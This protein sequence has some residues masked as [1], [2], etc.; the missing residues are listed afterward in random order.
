MTIAEERTF[1]LLARVR[2]WVCALPAHYVIEIMR[3]LPIQ[4]VTGAPPFVLGM[5]IVRGE[6]TPIVALEMLLGSPEANAPNRFVLVRAGERRVIL[7]V[8]EVLGVQEID[9]RHFDKA[10]GL[11]TETLPQDVARIG[12]LDRSV[13]VVLEA[14]RLLPETAWQGILVPGATA[15]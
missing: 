9:T 13:L 3:P 2:G 4:P 1:A 5:S 10:P 14:G 6:V 15:S 8:D 7:A 12:V 11:L